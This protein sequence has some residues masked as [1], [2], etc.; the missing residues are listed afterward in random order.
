PRPRPGPA[1]TPDSRRAPAPYGRHRP[2]IRADR[3]RPTRPARPPAARHFLPNSA[4]IARPSSGDSGLTADLKRPTTSP[5]RPM[6]NFSKFQPMAPANFGLVSL[7]VRY[8]YRGQI[9]GPLTTT[10]LII[11]KVT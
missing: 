7:A 4:S 8:L 11:G 9:S 6:R 1:Q 5:P 2:P 10:L 3:C